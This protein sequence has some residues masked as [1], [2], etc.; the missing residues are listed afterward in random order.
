VVINAIQELLT[1][2]GRASADAVAEAAL[3]ARRA[4]PDYT[5]TAAEEQLLTSRVLRVGAARG[6]LLTLLEAAVA[7]TPWVTKY[8]AEASFGLGSL[9]D[10][11]VAACRAEC[12]LGALVLHAEGGTVAFLDEERLEVLRG[13][14]PPAAI[15][16]VRAAAL[17]M[18]EDVLGEQACD[19]FG[20]A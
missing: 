3:H 19:C 10:P 8:A 5:L 20:F 14:A 17:D 7:A 6:A 1:N 9:A 18:G 11:Y 16:A 15:S 2:D 12:M 13:A 4:D